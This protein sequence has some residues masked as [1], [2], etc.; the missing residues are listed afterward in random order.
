VN[1]SSSVVIA[2]GLLL[3]TIVVVGTFD[4]NYDYTRRMFKE[5]FEE[6]PV[7]LSD[8]KNLKGNLVSLQYNGSHAPA[9]ILT[10]RWR[11]SDSDVSNNNSS[12]LKFSANITMVGPNGI[13]EHKHRLTNFNLLNLNLSASSAILRGT[14]SF[15]TSGTDS[16]G[17]PTQILNLPITIKIENLR[18]MNLDIDKKLVKYHFGGSPVFGTVSDTSIE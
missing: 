4:H 16:T 13:D 1:V 10:G 14:T 12:S 5:S 9:W 6:L 17:I 15:T 7:A 3:V 2:F 8:I 11:I 18:T